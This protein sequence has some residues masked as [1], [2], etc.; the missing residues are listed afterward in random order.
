MKTLFGLL[1][2]AIVCL[3]G[4]QACANI[5]E[6]DQRKKQAQTQGKYYVEL[7]DDVERVEGTCKFMR[8]INAIEDP[9]RIPSKA[10]TPDYFREKA[11]Y[12]GADTVLLR[13][14]V[15]DLY[16]CGQVGLN[17]DGTRQAPYPTPVPH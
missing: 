11:A 14:Q 2:A 4:I 16:T 13:G 7:T 1:C 5:N 12:Y 9:V 3:I 15:G 17:P 6:A 8:Q 10:E